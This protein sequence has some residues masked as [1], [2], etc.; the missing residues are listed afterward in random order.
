MGEMGN[1]YNILV[2]NIYCR[3]RYRC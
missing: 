1:E 2:E 3:P